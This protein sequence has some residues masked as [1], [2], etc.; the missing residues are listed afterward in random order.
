ML[1]II[2]TFLIIFILSL[3]AGCKSPQEESGVSA[4]PFNQ[5][6]EWENPENMGS[7]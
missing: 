1:N 3:L 6:A 7:N 2:H 5:P 4:I